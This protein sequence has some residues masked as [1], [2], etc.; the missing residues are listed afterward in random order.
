MNLRPEF[1]G[2]INEFL[3]QYRFYIGGALGLVI[4]FCIGCFVY[5]LTMLG[6]AALLGMDSKQGHA[7]AMKGLLVSG[8]SLAVLGS[9]EL[10]YLIF[11]FTI[12]G[13]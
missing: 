8:V 13:G 9:I 6:A 4:L 10:I 3:V 12:I 1:I 7:I 5:F 11:A 2:A